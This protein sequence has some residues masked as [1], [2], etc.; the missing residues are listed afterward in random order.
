[1]S[2]KAITKLKTLGSGVIVTVNKTAHGSARARRR[3]HDKAQHV[4]HATPRPTGWKPAW[5]D[6]LLQLKGAL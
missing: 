4:R 2:T 5:K 1:M 3:A 6:T